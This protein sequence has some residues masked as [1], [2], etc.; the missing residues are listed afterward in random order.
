VANS[1][2]PSGGIDA[3]YLLTGEKSLIDTRKPT[4]LALSASFYSA[5]PDVAANT[6]PPTGELTVAGYS[7]A[8]IH[9]A[10][11]WNAPV[12]AADGSVSKTN[13]QYIAV[14]PFAEAGPDAL[15]WFITTAAT[16]TAADASNIKAWGT[17]S[18]P[19]AVIAE[20]QI[21]WLPG[22]FTFTFR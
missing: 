21:V 6:T 18:V 1:L 5:D 20:L 16:G 13:A 10:G 8:P 7:R 3:L 12:T 11:I 17:L 2:A 15:S 9:T 19:K 14:G 4:Y 22:Q